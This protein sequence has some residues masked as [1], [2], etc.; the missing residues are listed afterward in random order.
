MAA[1]FLELL[2]VELFVVRRQ[3]SSGVPPPVGKGSGLQLLL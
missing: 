2:D 3:L 1:G